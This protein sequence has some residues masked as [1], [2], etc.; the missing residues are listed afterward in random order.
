[1]TFS[2]RLRVRSLGTATR[3]RPGPCRRQPGSGAV[4]QPVA[5]GRLL[6][7]WYS[8]IGGE[9]EEG[10]RAAQQQYGSTLAGHLHQHPQPGRLGLLDGCQ[11]RARRRRTDLHDPRRARRPAR[12]RRQ[13]VLPGEAAKWSRA[14]DRPAITVGGSLT[15]GTTS[16][17]V[18]R[19]DPTLKADGMIRTEVN[20]LLGS[21][22]SAAS[23]SSP[24]SSTTTTTSWRPFTNTGNTD[25]DP[26]IELAGKTVTG[27]VLHW[28]WRWSVNHEVRYLVGN[29]TGWGKNT[30]VDFRGD[31]LGNVYGD[32]PDEKFRAMFAWHGFFP[33]RTVTYNNIGGP[34]CGRAFLRSTSRRPTRSGGSRLPVHR[35]RPRS[36]PP[37]RPTAPPTTRAAVAG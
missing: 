19:V 33:E 32:R 27:L 1:M 20:T 18:D 13:R 23:T 29:S 17:V 25:A 3:R 12:H 14:F 28:Q 30:M 6:H 5:L 8:E 2:P 11:E 37:A 36:T 15:E 4:H 16:F 31:G 21:R 35:R 22:S 34:S 9:K 24:T 10:A 26:E 7:N